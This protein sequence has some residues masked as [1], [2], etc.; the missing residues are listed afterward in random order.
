MLGYD[1]V[2]FFMRP[3]HTA[4][5]RNTTQVP[6]KEATAEPRRRHCTA[7]AAVLLLRY[8]SLVFL[9]P[10]Y[11]P[12]TTLALP[13][14][15]NSDPGLCCSPV[16]LHPIYYPCTTLALPPSSNSDPGSHSGSSS[17]LSTRA[18]IFYHENNSAFSSLSS[19][20]VELYLPFCFVLLCVP[21]M[22]HASGIYIPG[23]Y[24]VQLTF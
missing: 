8:C 16:F 19:T 24:D 12:C 3:Y 9:Y 5:L 21:K 10:I 17:P 22:Y 1:T 4:V 6:E 7:A 11:Y 2:N 15:S 20:P 13:P 18:F 14:S 23:M